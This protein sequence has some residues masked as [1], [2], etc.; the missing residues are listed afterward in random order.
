MQS[1]SIKALPPLPPLLLA[2]QVNSSELP[3]TFNMTKCLSVALAIGAIG[4]GSNLLL[5]ALADPVRLNW[6]HCERTAQLAAPRAAAVQG[7]QPQRRPSPVRPAGAALNQAV[8]CG[9]AGPQGGTPS[10]T[11]RTRPGC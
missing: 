4:T 2:S 9:A 11:P 3:E 1:A 6:W 7:P 10:W 8:V 5:F